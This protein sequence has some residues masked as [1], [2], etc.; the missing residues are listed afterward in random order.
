MN[1]ELA[2]LL[3]PPEIK[4]DRPTAFRD[5]YIFH[6][7]IHP[8]RASQHSHQPPSAIRHPPKPQHALFNRKSAACTRARTLTSS[9]TLI[10][11]TLAAAIA[12][13][14]IAQ[15]AALAKRWKPTTCNAIGPEGLTLETE[16]LDDIGRLPVA[17]APHT[18]DA[19]S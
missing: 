4:I 3:S 6:Q 18:A 1:S 2:R 11:A 15:P 19:R 12:A 5:T 13:S 17:R 16:S 8:F 7:Q 10:F 14:P 9:Q